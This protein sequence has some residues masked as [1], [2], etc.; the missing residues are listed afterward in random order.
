MILTAWVGLFVAVGA[1]LFVWVTVH[2]D[3][4]IAYDVI[5]Q[6]ISPTDP[7][8]RGFGVGEYLLGIFGYFVAPAIIGAV[9]AG[10]FVTNSTM[11]EERAA[12]G[13]ALAAKLTR[14]T[15]KHRKKP[16]RTGETKDSR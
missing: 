1:G 4:A 10:V 2:Q 9:V 7:Q 16:A 6:H 12:K 3:A 11:S 8:R 15:G 14:L 5:T 13:L